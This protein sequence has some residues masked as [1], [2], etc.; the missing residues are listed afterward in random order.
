MTAT[1]A[2]LER[3]HSWKGL[4][5]WRHLECA[6]ARLEGAFLAGGFWVAQYWALRGNHERAREILDSGLAYAN[7]VGLFAEEGEPRGESAGT[8]LG[9]VPQSFVH[10]A[11]IGAVI[12]LKESMASS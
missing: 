12:D 8:M 10:A 11:F 5:Y 1:I 2:A 7:D 6:D 9:N 4:L 3:D